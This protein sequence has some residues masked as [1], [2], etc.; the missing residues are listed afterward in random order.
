MGLRPY[1]IQLQHLAELAWCCEAELPGEVAHPCRA[2]LSDGWR[3]PHTV[4]QP[5]TEHHVTHF[6]QALAN[7]LLHP[8]PHIHGNSVL[9]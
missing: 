6:G 3:G 4:D 8:L 1:R 2:A 7:Y 9:L 5:G